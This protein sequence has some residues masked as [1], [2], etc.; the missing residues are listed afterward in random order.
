MRFTILPAAL[1]LSM[2]SAG[3]AGANRFFF[4][5]TSG[6]EQVEIAG[7][8]ITTYRRAMT[9]GGKYTLP[10]VTE[11]DLAADIGVGS[12]IDVMGYAPGDYSGTM[13]FEDGIAIPLKVTPDGKVGEF[14][15]LRFSADL[16][17]WAVGQTVP[18]GNTWDLAR[19]A[20]TVT[21]KRGGE[22]LSFD[23]QVQI[24]KGEWLH[25]IELGRLNV[26]PPFWLEEPKKIVDSD[27][28]VEVHLKLH[29]ELG[30]RLPLPPVKFTWD[31]FY[32]DGNWED[33]MEAEAT[34]LRTTDGYEAV[35]SLRFGD[36]YFQSYTASVWHGD[37]VINYVNGRVLVTPTLGDSDL[38][39][40]WDAKFLAAAEIDFGEIGYAFA[41]GYLGNLDASVGL[42]GYSVEVTCSDGS[43]MRG[44][45]S[46]NTKVFGSDI[47][48]MVQPHVATQGV[49]TVYITV[50]YRDQAATFTSSM[51][52]W[53]RSGLP[54][55]LPEWETG[56]SYPYNDGRGWDIERIERR[57]LPMILPPSRQSASR[58]DE[59]VVE[60]AEASESDDLEKLEAW[61]A[62]A[63]LRIGIWQGNF[64][65]NLLG[66]DDEDLLAEELGFLA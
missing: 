4:V 2:A 30:G 47:V 15:R 62:W 43:P 33:S 37:T 38:Y 54:E 61:W 5:V 1:I 23:S 24:R 13:T 52:V 53:P 32:R 14:A 66:K 27:G 36:D 51:D 25:P 9:A 46:Q 35:A 59:A 58:E 41:A 18:P 6:F 21:V 48:V 50:R 3:L 63:E 11:G 55:V 16:T 42:D 7:G 10:N 45:V 44:Y 8:T 40:A 20:Y 39:L 17:A 31:S 34:I 19:K 57:P 12:V 29:D 64:D 22:T 56:S 26:P 60:V 28:S 49:K 65:L